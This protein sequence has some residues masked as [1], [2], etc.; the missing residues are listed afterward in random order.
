MIDDGVEYHGH[1][2]FDLNT[3][4]YYR[5]ALSAEEFYKVYPDKV[6]GRVTHILDNEE[7]NNRLLK[8][9]SEL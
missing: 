7:R 6:L 1:F 3:V 2:L 8:K 5:Q 9:L 4:C